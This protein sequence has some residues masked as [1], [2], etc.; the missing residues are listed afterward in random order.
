MLYETQTTIGEEHGRTRYPMVTKMSDQRSARSNTAGVLQNVTT[1]EYLM[2]QSV[3]PVLHAIVVARVLPFV[4]LHNRLHLISTVTLPQYGAYFPKALWRYC[5]PSTLPLAVNIRFKHVNPSVMYGHYTKSRYNG[6]ASV[7]R[8]SAAVKGLA[9]NY[10]STI[11]QLRFQKIQLGYLIL[12]QGIRGLLFKS[13]LAVADVA[14][15][16][17]PIF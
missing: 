1:K 2:S 6:S 10:F 8:I 17:L 15:N 13:L 11:L 7:A 16:C 9:V 12:A 5:L 14:K 3:H 4:N